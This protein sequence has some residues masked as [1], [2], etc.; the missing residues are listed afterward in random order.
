MQ[1]PFIDFSQQYQ[2]IKDEIDVGLT[3]V[4]KKGNFILGQEEKDFEKHFAHYCGSA[5]G[6]G[7]NSGT[8]ALY[9]ALRAL[10]INPGDEVIIPSFTFIATALGISSIGAKPV[11][12]DVEEDT[13]N[14]DPK[15]IKEAIT[16]KTRVIIVVHL[17][18]QSAAMDE[19]KAIAR[20]H[21]IKI[22]EDAAPGPTERCT[23]IK[24][25]DL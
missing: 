4:F 22:I 20:E 14:V 7:V 24:K 13:F 6:I 11:L 3:H 8:D 21:N 12:V 1:V 16:D 15:K 25:S 5:Y 2:T 19:I 23:V 18:G 17:Y 10:G 9:L